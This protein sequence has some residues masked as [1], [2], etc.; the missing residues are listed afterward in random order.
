MNNTFDRRII[1]FDDIAGRYDQWEETPLGALTSR[2]EREIIITLF[3]EA[4]CTGPVLDVGCGTGNMALL[5]AR[6]G[7]TVSGVDISEKMLHHARQKA[8]EAGI[9]VDFRQADASRLPFPNESFGTV[10][11][12]LTIEFS[13]RP[14]DVVQ[15]IYRVLRPG[16]HL[17]LATLN[18]RSLWTVARKIKGRR[19]P[20]VYNQARFFSR[21]EVAGLL[22][23]AGFANHMW[24]SAIY[25]PPIEKPGLL[26][27]YRF[28]ESFGKVVLPGAAAFIAVQGSKQ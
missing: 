8:V 22:D 26:R 13:N 27:F 1:S 28:F 25:Y 4:R 18:R 9:K 14:E 2:L 12:L 6:R 15:E 24:S 7:L 10:T 23:D 21:K 16:G 17:I 5:F 20:T 19:Q 11:C 3:E